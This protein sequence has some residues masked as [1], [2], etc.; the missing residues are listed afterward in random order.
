MGR[1][2]DVSGEIEKFVII[3]FFLYKHQIMTIYSLPR[4]GLL[5]A[6]FVLFS[7][8]LGAAG[9]HAESTMPV[10][11]EKPTLEKTVETVPQPLQKPNVVQTQRVEEA[12]K[13]NNKKLILT[14]DGGF[15]VVEDT[16]STSSKLI[17]SDRQ[18]R[19]NREIFNSQN[20]GRIAEADKKINQLN[21]KIILGHI[22]AE[23]YLHPTA[24]NASY[25]ELA[26]W[27]KQYADH[28][29]A[30]RIYK[31]ALKYSKPSSSLIKPI[32]HKK[33]SGNLSAISQRGKIYKS[34]KRRSKDQ[35]NR[36][37]KLTREIERNINSQR[38]TL[39]L[40]T[41]SNDYA[42]QFMDDAEYDRQRALIASGFL[43][44]GKLDDAL[45]L[46]QSSLKRSGKNV[47]VAGWVRGMVEWQ[48]GDYGDAASAFEVTAS[49]PYSSGWL[50]SA[51]AYWASRA[52]MRN[53][54]SE[55]ISKWLTLATTYPRTF[56]GLVA[57]RALG[58]NNSFNW[59]I[60]TLS[61]EDIKI[62]ENTNQGK[63]AYALIQSGQSALAEMELKT[64]SFNDDVRKKRALL[65]YANNYNLPSL[66]MS[67]GNSFSGPRGDFYDAA[68]YPLTSWEPEGGFIVDK[69]LMHAVIRQES[70]FNQLASN[71]S[72]ATGLMQ[73]MPSTA[74][75]VSGQKIYQEASGQHQLKKPELNMALGQKYI[76]E[77]LNYNSVNQDL[78]SMAIA[79]NAGPGNLSK[80]KSE[81]SHVKDPLLFIE[82][83]PFPETRAFVERVMANYWI[84]KMRLNEPTP[85]LDAVAEGK[86]AQRVA[87]NN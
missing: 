82:T 76:Q 79:Y 32:N 10:P 39:A 72:G 75:H 21:N 49:S 16:P 78:L 20:Q 12:I 8:V 55:L 18:A 85:S 1:Y 27:M 6:G 74:N 7:S 37:N 33:I 4:N 69:S 38:L 26:S 60:P 48:R 58:N 80:W 52:H 41:L 17:F 14:S 9:V 62:V 24:Y 34:T 22:L 42:V 25:A 73:L 11:P 35:Q 13:P 28:P 54:N 45:R 19:L 68:L 77:L 3:I 43:Y 66:L 56:Y 30:A 67:L 61:R 47:P 40:N 53:G 63:R 86:W 50:V 59:D 36:V 83:I 23:R 5:L 31:L 81:R 57:T 70:R 64:L 46:A 71:P 84:Y 29:Q 51:A 2:V 87:A 15:K 65:S 44:A